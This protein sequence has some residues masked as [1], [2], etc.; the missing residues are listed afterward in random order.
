MSRNLTVETGKICWLRID[1][2]AYTVQQKGDD[3]M[4]DIAI[5]A[6]NLSKMYHIGGQRER[7]RTM[8]DTLTDAFVAP[9]RRARKLVRGQATGAAE[10]DQ[11][12]WA[13]DDVSFEVKRGETIGIIGRNG[14]GKTTLLKI[15]SRITEPTHGY[16]DIYGRVGALLEV[17]T[18]FHPELTGRENIFLNGAIL[19]MKRT[20]IE[21]QFDEI[22]AFAE[23]SQYIDT[24]VKHYSS[25][26]YVRLAFSVAAHLE[27]DILLVDE[28][29]AVGDALFQKKCLGKMGDVA[30]EGRTVVFVSHN[31]ATVASL[32]TRGYLI[33]QGCLISEGDVEDVISRY[34]NLNLESAEI[35]LGN[36]TDRSGNGQLRFTSLS[37]EDEAGYTLQTA[38]SGQTIAISLGYE[39]SNN[40]PIP[41]VNFGITCLNYLGQHMFQCRTSLIQDTYYDLPPTGTVRCIIPKLPLVAGEYVIRIWALSGT[42]WLDR[43]DSAQRLSVVSGD[44]YGSGKL[45][46]RKFQGLLIPHQWEA[47]EA[48]PV[49]NLE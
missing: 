12:M 41:D 40:E 8:R 19:G 47:P 3:R 48:L 9:F 35:P 18:G 27:P 21:R 28:V 43:F 23:I 17:G 5:S 33:D 2:E 20:E 29:L 10:L 7:Y 26:M 45:P 42:E 6:H 36:R 44:F 34:L 30:Q 37:I 16:A 39:L 11:V 22:V 4:N 38:S 13:L 49:S 1:D 32:C 31:L 25:G 14:A 24:P 46:G 15:L